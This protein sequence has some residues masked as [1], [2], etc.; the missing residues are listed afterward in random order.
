MY[1]ILPH[2]INGDSLMKNVNSVSVRIGLSTMSGIKILQDSALIGNGTITSVLTQ[3]VHKA[4]KEQELAV[5]CKNGYF[6]IGDKLIDAEGIELT[7]LTI[8]D[9]MAKLKS[10]E[11]GKNNIST[12]DICGGYAWR[13]TGVHNA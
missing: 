10:F 5:S 4:I 1:A 13:M 12:I 2:Q 3:L 8:K 11:N 6:T 9:G 7:I